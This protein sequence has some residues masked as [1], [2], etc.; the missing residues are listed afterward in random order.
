MPDVLPPFVPPPGSKIVDPA[1]IVVPFKAKA[2]GNGQGGPASNQHFTTQYEGG[3]DVM[4]D[5]DCLIKDML[6]ER[7]LAFLGGQHSMGKTYV[8]LELAQ[9]VITGAEFAGHQIER[10]GG[11]L[12]L[13]AEGVDVIRKR[14]TAIKKAK[15]APMLEQLGE[16]I[17][18]MP[19]WWTLTM[20]KLTDQDAKQ[21]FGMMIANIKQELI[22]RGHDCPLSLIVVDTLMSASSFKDAKDS[23]QMQHVMDMLRWMSVESGALVVVVD[24]LGKDADRGLRDSSVK[25][26]AADAIMSILGERSATGVVTNTRLA[27]AKLRGGRAGFE[28]PFNLIEC[29]LGE[30]RD[31]DPITEL[32][33]KW[34]GDRHTKPD[35]PRKAAKPMLEAMT[36]AL[37]AH[38]ETVTP[39]PGMSPLRAVNAKHVRDAFDHAYPVQFDT[40]EKKRKAASRQA[41]KRAIDACKG[42]VGSH[43]YSTERELM[44]LIRDEPRP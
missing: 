39:R 7:G 25:E 27:L 40:D 44:W 18:P 4:P 14:W 17:G 31:G 32:I 13:A 38:G 10:P 23:A 43:R 6:P 29:K 34:E 11:V 2:Q 22:D 41:W 9:A 20:P 15:V 12:F 33:V 8:A 30:D 28:V 42:L 26:Q 1:S 37:L 35:G 3:A 5:F 36:E 19:L 24:H 16:T 21:Q